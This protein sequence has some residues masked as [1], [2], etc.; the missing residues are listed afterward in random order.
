MRLYYQSFQAT[1]ILCACEKW[2]CSI[3]FDWVW[4]YI[5]WRKHLHLNRSAVN[6]SS[7]NIMTWTEEVNLKNR[8]GKK[9]E[10]VVDTFF[11]G[12]MSKLFF[13]CEK[14]L[15]E[16]VGVKL[17][18]KVFCLKK[19]KTFPSRHMSTTSVAALYTSSCFKIHIQVGSCYLSILGIWRKQPPLTHIF[20]FS[21][22]V[23]LTDWLQ[24]EHFSKA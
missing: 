24:G 12:K 7:V 13:K 19:I 18:M 21:S 22:G 3:K 6:A 23:C 17:C 9:E 5:L 16:Y 15:L 20:I 10:I 8:I 14:F 1:S 11:T 2:Y 4:W